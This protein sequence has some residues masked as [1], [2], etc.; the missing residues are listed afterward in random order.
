MAFERQKTDA[1]I[2]AESALRTRLT[3]EWTERLKHEVAAAADQAAAAS[4][5]EQATHEQLSRAHERALLAQ[6][7]SLV[8]AQVA[9]RLAHALTRP[10]YP[11][12]ALFDVG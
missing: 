12:S 8:I 6:M 7:E 10:Y 9:I 11:T 1:V 2:E 3:Q 4:R 5:Q